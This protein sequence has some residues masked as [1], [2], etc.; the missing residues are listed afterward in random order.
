MGRASGE[1]TEQPGR[2]IDEATIRRAARILLDAAHPVLL[3]LFGSHAR[4]RAGPDS[5]LDFLVVER[6]VPDRRA[7]MVRLRDLLRPL[8]IPVDLVVT[9]EAAFAKWSK[10]EG[11]VFAEAAQRGRRLDVPA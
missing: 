2:D 8:R 7:E 5:D 11:T 9:S 10:V 6:E 1:M 4:G 3:I